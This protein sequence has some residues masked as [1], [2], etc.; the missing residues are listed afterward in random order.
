MSKSKLS[1]KQATTYDDAVKYLE[2]LVK[3]F[4][5][6]KIVLQQGEEFV[7]LTP[8]ENVVVEVSAKQKKGKAKVEVEISW[9]ESVEEGEALSISDSE[10]EPAPEAPA[11]EGE[12]AK[13]DDQLDKDEKAEELRHGD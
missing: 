4:K 3:S 6:G 7:S 9:M 8:A 11:A 13:G 5:V 12:E 10:P 1:V 2:D